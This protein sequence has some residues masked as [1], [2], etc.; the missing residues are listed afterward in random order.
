MEENLSKNNYPESPKNGNWKVLVWV[1][2]IVV[3]FTFIII[4]LNS[5][6]YNPTQTPPLSPVST[7]TSTPQSNLQLSINSVTS[8]ASRG[9]YATLSATGTPDGLARI[10]VY[11]KSG[12]SHA[13]GLYDKMID[14]S[15]NVSWS[16]FVGTNTTS[17]SWQ[18]TVT[19]SLNEQT[20]SKTTYFTVY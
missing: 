13:Q 9:S 1:L 17:G 16:W 14:S 19:E 10:V 5:S 20:V 4:A 11:Y 18:I 15:G 6:S 7:Q 2:G 8:P 3:L 12:P